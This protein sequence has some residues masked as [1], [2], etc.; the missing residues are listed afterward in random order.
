M[1]ALLLLAFFWLDDIWCLGAWPIARSRGES[2]RGSPILY[3]DRRRLE[4]TWR[5]VS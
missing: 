1:A 2:L 3:F 4:C 5:F